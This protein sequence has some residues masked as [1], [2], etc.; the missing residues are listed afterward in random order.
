MDDKVVCNGI[1]K[2][3]K[4]SNKRIMITIIQ[5]SLNNKPRPYLTGIHSEAK[6]KNEQFHQIIYK[7]KSH[8]SYRIQS[9]KIRT[10]GIYPTKISY[11]KASIKLTKRE[12]YDLTSQKRNYNNNL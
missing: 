3:D 1:T 10:S 6:T 12:S 5:I 7:V 8:F 11:P 2:Q 4:K 9:H